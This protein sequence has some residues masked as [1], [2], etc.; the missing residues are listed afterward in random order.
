M[1]VEKEKD[2]DDVLS[3]ISLKETP[4]QRKK[5]IGELLAR[6]RERQRRESRRRRHKLCF[7]WSMAASVLVCV[8]AAWGVFYSDV[9]IEAGCRQVA[10]CLPDESEVELEPDAY[11]CYNRLKWY[12]SRELFLSGEASFEVTKGETFRVNTLAGSVSV[13]GTK[14]TIVQKGDSMRVDCTE[15]S[16]RVENISDS[17]VLHAGEGVDCTP[18]GITAVEQPEYLIYNN[19]PLSEVLHKI[20]DIYQ[21]TIQLKRNVQ[22]MKY[23]GGVSTVNRE[24]AL[25][26][27]LGSCNLSYA[28]EGN[29]VIIKK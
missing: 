25:E 7:C 4:F 26:V 13:L 2:L 29:H 27:V 16:V 8:V 14:F 11:L 20:E 5:E 15:G 12:F 21:V 23:T 18:G 6:E 1:S 10:V 17:K 28:V 9:M 3:S 22:D 24:E 19:A